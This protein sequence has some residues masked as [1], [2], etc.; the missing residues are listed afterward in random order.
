MYLHIYHVGSSVHFT[1]RPGG[2]WVTNRLAVKR[3]ILPLIFIFTS[4]VSCDIGFGWKWSNNGI[5]LIIS[6][7]GRVRHQSTVLTPTRWHE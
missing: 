5:N 1:P 3:C 2:V 4:L 6:I 7:V